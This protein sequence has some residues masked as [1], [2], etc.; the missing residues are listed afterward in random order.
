MS[1]LCV[2][3][4][5]CSSLLPFLTYTMPALSGVLLIVVALSMGHGSG[6]IIYICVSVLSLFFV[7]DKEC[8]VMFTAFF[9]YYPILKLQFDHFHSKIA[10]VSL[11]YLL[12]NAAVVLSQWVVIKVLGMPLELLDGLGVWTIPVL[13]LLANLLFLLYD[14]ML[15]QIQRG[16]H[17]KWHKYVERLFRL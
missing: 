3:L 11:K 16:Y 13:L 9:G 17:I 2:A 15:T 1:A 8:A 14:L 6:W 12:F 5:L 7:T 4:M 10:K